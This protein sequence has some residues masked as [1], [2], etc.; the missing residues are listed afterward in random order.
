MQSGVLSELKLISRLLKSVPL[1]DMAASENRLYGII[2]PLNSLSRLFS[3]QTGTNPPIL[4]I[5]Q[6]QVNNSNIK[7]EILNI[8]LKIPLRQE[9]KNILLL[10]YCILTLVPSLILFLP[11]CVVENMT[12]VLLQYRSTVARYICLKIPDT[13][14][15]P[16]LFSS[17]PPPTVCKNT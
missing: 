4:S 8:H 16:V 7:L 14:K 5:S 13:F 12:A 11:A 2:S 9:E 6:N 1:K 17:P 15:C 10:L 3:L